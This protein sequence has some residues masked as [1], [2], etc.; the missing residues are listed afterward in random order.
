[1]AFTP[2]EALGGQLQREQINKALGEVDAGVGGATN[3]TYTASTRVIASSTGTDA[4]L[5]LVTSGDAGLAPASGGGTT[6][7]LRADGTW[8]APGGGVSDGDKGDITVSGG[9]ATW[10]VDNNAITL[11]KMADVAT[12][13]VFYRKTA[14]T[15]DPEVQTLA[16]LKTDLGLTGT[17]SGDQT[18]TLTGDVTG[19]GTGSFAATIAN[20]AVTNAKLANMAANT[21]KGNNTGG[22][23]DPVDL[24]AAQVRTLINV[25]DGAQVNVPTDLSY[26]ASTRLLA[27]STGADVTLPLFTSTEAGLT[28]LSG[29]GTT[30]FLRA[31]GT[32]A[33]PPA[34]GS[35]ALTDLTDVTVSAAAQGQV[36]TRGA[37]EFQN[38]TLM[39]VTL[40]PLHINDLPGTATTQA[41]NGYFNTAT[42]LSRN[43]NDMRMSRAGRVVGLIMV[44][45][46]A[47]TAGTATARVRVAGAG[48]TFDG[49]SVQLNATD[50]T[51]DSSFVAYGS[52]VAFTAGQ[53]IGADVVTSGWTPITANVNVYV[54]VMFEPF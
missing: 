22:A 18:I 2:V 46:A 32:W 23:A 33:A 39:T 1:M 15:G 14:G 8:A 17:N 41:T 52:G 50:T 11:A 53:T 21:I 6:N 28:P 37:S 51:S 3:L 20:D 26:T 45:D 44:S 9:G 27:S 35:L 29:G 25:A 40:G 19:S 16:T 31:D 48:T 43:A 10:T 34:G 13:T 47:R 4:T 42:A 36:L 5:P 12:S 7:F 24:T 49:G 54:V 30:N 38:L